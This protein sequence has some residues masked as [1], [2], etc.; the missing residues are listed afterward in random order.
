MY[1]GSGQN[2]ERHWGSPGILPSGVRFVD[3]PVLTDGLPA[4]LRRV[5]GNGPQ[6]VR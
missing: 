2:S 5:A 3:L 6:A 1:D 4:T